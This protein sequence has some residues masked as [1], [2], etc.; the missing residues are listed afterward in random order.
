MESE[1]RSK[2]AADKAFDDLIKILDDRGVA[3]LDRFI[4]AAKEALL[5]GDAP[6]PASDDDAKHTHAYPYWRNFPNCPAC[7]AT[8]ALLPQSDSGV[9]E[10]TDAT[11][12]FKASDI[13]KAAHN[14]DGIDVTPPLKEAE[15]LEA[16]K[17]QLA[18]IEHERWG[19]WQSWVHQ[20]IVGVEGIDLD[21]QMERWQKLIDT[22]YDKLSDDKRRSDLNQVE[23]Y[24]PL[25]QCYV[26]QR[27]K[28]E[29]EA[30]IKNHSEQHITKQEVIAVHDNITKGSTLAM[31][32]VVHLN[33]RI[34]EIDRKLNGEQS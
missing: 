16:L 21:E 31:V 3:L 30:A 20:V 15:T 8:A 14:K 32:P 22:P 5:N 6:K 33:D 17:E 19:D 1:P 29:L 9:E 25:I 27:L 13:E 24:W 18:A 12:L 10:G 4:S 34:A 7:A 11:P 26:D 23:R 28:R 2:E